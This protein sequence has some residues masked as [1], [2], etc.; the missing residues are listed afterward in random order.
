MSTARLISRLQLTTWRQ[1][2]LLAEAVLMLAGASLAIK[3][4]PFRTLMAPLGRPARIDPDAKRRAM[5]TVEARWGVRA[6]APFLPWRIVC[7]QKG[8][9]LHLMLRRRGVPSILHYGVAQA[10]EDGIKAHVWVS[11]EGVDLI[12]GAEARGFTCLATFPAA[13]A[14]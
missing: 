3:L 13:T 8:V 1:R 9:A 12:G 5:R 7:F 2:L 6:A 14:T 4:L 11:A 10:G